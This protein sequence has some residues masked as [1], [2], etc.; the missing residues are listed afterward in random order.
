MSC[1]IWVVNQFGNLSFRSPNEKSALSTMRKSSVPQRV[2]TSE[3]SG[4]YNSTYQ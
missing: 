4:Q 3:K 1:H 2:A